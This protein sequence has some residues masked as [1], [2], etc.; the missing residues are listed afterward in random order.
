MLK[1]VRQGI[2]GDGKDFKLDGQNIL[3]KWFPQ[4][5]DNKYAEVERQNKKVKD[6]NL[7]AMAVEMF[8]AKEKRKKEAAQKMKEAVE[9]IDEFTSKMDRQMLEDTITV[10]QNKGFS[11]IWLDLLKQKRKVIK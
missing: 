10:W 7:G 4:Y 1:Q 11:K 8:Y 5:L 2:I 6:E 3:A 9:K